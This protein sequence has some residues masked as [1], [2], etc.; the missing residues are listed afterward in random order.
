MRKRNVYNRQ[1]TSKR[2]R[3]GARA[4]ILRSPTLQRCKVEG[5]ES[6]NGIG[7]SKCATIEQ[8]LGDQDGSPTRREA[9]CCMAW[10]LVDA[11]RAPPLCGSVSQLGA[12]PGE[13]ASDGDRAQAISRRFPS[14]K[15]A[16]RAS[17]DGENDGATHGCDVSA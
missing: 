1:K 11:V 10:R 4:G 9:T 6:R 12:R 3:T 16:R 2:A 8:P 15:A 14:P 17:G 13:A 5:S 7:R